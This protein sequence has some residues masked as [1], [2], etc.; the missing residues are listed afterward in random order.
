MPGTVTFA[1][2]IDGWRT[3]ASV[4]QAPTDGRHAPFAL[5]DTFGERE[6]ISIAHKKRLADHWV[7]ALSESALADQGYAAFEEFTA[8]AQLS[9]ADHITLYAYPNVEERT[10]R[11]NLSSRLSPVEQREMNLSEV[12]SDTAKQIALTDVELVP[13]EV[14]TADGTERVIVPQFGLGGRIISA[15]SSL[16]TM[17]PLRADLEVVAF[18]FETMAGL[19]ERHGDGVAQ[20]LAKIRAEHKHLLQPPNEEMDILA[21][22]LAWVLDAPRDTHAADFMARYLTRWGLP[23]KQEWD[24]AELVATSDAI[25]GMLG[26]DRSLA[27]LHV[28]RSRSVALHSQRELGQGI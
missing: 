5:H 3:V 22:R 16:V 4:A 9:G 15:L 23:P 19:L 13:I 18:A 26:I 11:R 21:S 12:A 24:A 6:R 17:N 1:E 27:A 25:T 10:R 28:E 8:A 2:E 20:Q 7:I 14:V